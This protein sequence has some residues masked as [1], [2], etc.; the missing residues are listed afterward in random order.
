VAIL[1]GG[2][3]TL[4]VKHAEDFLRTHLPDCDP[5]VAI[6]NQIIDGI[7]EDRNMTKVNDMLK[8][9]NLHRLSKRSIQRLFSQYVGVSPKWVIQR[10]RLHEAAE[11]LATGNTVNWTQLAFDLG[12]FD[13]AHFIKDF[14]ALVG[15]TPAEYARQCA[16]NAL[17]LDASF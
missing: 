13:Q 15:K 11:Q 3:M 5:N 10:T 7:I 12:Y 9:I 1:T 14:K 4:M 17:T 2:D 16:S 6:V 8:Q